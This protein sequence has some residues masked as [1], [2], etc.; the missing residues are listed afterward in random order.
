[1]SE[2]SAGGLCVNYFPADA[3]QYQQ[4]NKVLIKLAASWAD[5]SRCGELASH[6]ESR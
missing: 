2:A 1:M 6:P 5:G 4:P 3:P